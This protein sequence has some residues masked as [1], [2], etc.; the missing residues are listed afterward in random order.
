MCIVLIKMYQTVLRSKQ[1][2]QTMIHKK[3][4]QSKAHILHNKIYYVTDSDN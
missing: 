1:N 4:R 3:L 2:H